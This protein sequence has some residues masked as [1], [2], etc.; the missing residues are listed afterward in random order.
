MSY[1][2]TDTIDWNDIYFLD[3]WLDDNVSDQYKEQPMA[4]DWAR[5]AKVVEEVGEAIQAFIGLTGQ[6]PRK[7]FTHSGEEFTGEMADSILTLVLCLQH[8]TKDAQM[9]KRIISERIAYRL[10]KAVKP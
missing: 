8:F 5:L 3:Q 10:E 4:Q 2:E 6:N 9:T 7:G 1:G